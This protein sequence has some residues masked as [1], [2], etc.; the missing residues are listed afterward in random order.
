MV[1]CR[2]MADY[3]ITGRKGN[4]KS[5]FAVG[6]ILDAL[7]AG[8]RV[9]TNLNI[10]LDKLVHERAKCTLIRLPDVPIADDL[11]ALGRGQAGVIEEEN[12]IIV[13]DECSKFFNAREW[14]DKSRAPLLDWL[15][16]SRKHGWDVYL[17]AQGAN[18]LDKQL[19]S[20]LLEYHV[21]VVR[22]DKW[23]I[24]FVGNLGKLRPC[25][26]PFTFPKMHFGSIRQGFH[27]DS[28]LVDRKWY[29]GP[30]LYS[31][32]DTQQVFL[33]RDNPSACGLH[34]VLSPW[35]TVGRYLPPLPKPLTDKVRDWWNGAYL[36]KPPPPKPK[37]PIVGLLAKLPPEQAVKHWRRFDALGAFA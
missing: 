3:L 14:Q 19:R 11:I 33:E 28:M 29:R 26:K 27:A 13:L 10:H 25:R 6:V 31:A 1:G 15:V 9:A 2:E 16:H 23:K 24:P 4:G 30:P 36:P 5:I 18:Q 37:H 32:Y 35:H 12:G 17:I 22:T 8:K 21:H 34:T 7:L 20:T